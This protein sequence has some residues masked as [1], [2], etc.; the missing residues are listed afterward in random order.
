M[1]MT[2]EARQWVDL[3][4]IKFS[5]SIIRVTLKFNSNSFLKK[6]INGLSFGILLGSHRGE[7][8]DTI[9]TMMH[10]THHEQI[11]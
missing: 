8:V 11:W 5:M 6:V 3:E 1:I 9:T 4:V 2:I 7:A 10:I